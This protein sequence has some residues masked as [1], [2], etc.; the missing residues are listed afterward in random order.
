MLFTGSGA[1]EPARR[2]GLKAS[3]IDILYLMVAK[4]GEGCEIRNSGTTE[5]LIHAAKSITKEPS[6]ED[7]SEAG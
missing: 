5:E 6:D 7:I 4:Y 3:N 1:T 2:A